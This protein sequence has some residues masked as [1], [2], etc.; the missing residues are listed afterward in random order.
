MVPVIFAVL[1]VLGGC[2]L[3]RMPKCA[4]LRSVA[5]EADVGTI[6]VV[7]PEASFG[8]NGDSDTAGRSVLRL[9]RMRNLVEPRQNAEFL[10][11]VAGGGIVSVV[12]RGTPSLAVGDRVI[13]LRGK[14]T[15]LA[16]LRD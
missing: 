4:R 9:L 1:A 11:R 8:E 12:Q 6:L 10:I 2:A 16:A 7:R 14:G 15:R 13:I 3:E 5:S